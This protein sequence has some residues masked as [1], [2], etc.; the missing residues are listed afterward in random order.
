MTAFIAVASAVLYGVAGGMVAHAAIYLME[1][2][3]R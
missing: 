1:R 3:I 2:L